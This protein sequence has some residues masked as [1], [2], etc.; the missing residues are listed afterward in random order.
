M[1]HLLIDF[2]GIRCFRK[3]YKMGQG[4]QFMTLRKPMKTLI[5]GL[6]RVGRVKSFNAI[7]G[8]FGRRGKY[9]T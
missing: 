7:F 8:D 2:G 6:S 5:K 1:L 3:P 4:N 9:H